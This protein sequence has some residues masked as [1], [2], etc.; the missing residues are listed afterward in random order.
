MFLLLI[1][2]R[3][4]SNP[5]FKLWTCTPVYIAV[6]FRLPETPALGVELSESTTM[7]TAAGNCQ[8]TLSKKTPREIP[9]HSV[10]YTKLWHIL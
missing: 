5:Y 3:P 10:T 6:H 7:L 1:N 4:I 2:G 8:S 9:T